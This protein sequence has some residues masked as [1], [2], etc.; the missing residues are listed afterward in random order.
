MF[1]IYYDISSAQLSGDF[2][3]DFLPQPGPAEVL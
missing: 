3:L 1:T 2:S